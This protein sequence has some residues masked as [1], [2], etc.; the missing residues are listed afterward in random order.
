MAKYA[1]APLFVLLT[2]REAWQNERRKRE[3]KTIVYFGASLISP[4]KRPLTSQTEKG[5]KSR[6]PA[7]QTNRRRNKAER[8]QKGRGRKRKVRKMYALR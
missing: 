8:R 1:K 7:S 6:K 4:L 3:K 2:R 5:K